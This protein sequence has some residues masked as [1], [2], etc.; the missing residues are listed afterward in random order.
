[1]AIIVMDTD[2]STDLNTVIAGASVGDV[3]EFT[4][5]QEALLDLSGGFVTADGL[6]FRSQ[7]AGVRFPMRVQRPSGSNRF[8]IQGR[9]S[10]KDIEMIIDRVSDTNGQTYMINAGGNNPN[11]FNCLFR[12]DNTANITGIG[13]IEDFSAGSYTKCEFDMRTSG[14]VKGFR[15]A[16]NDSTLNTEARY[17]CCEFYGNGAYATSVGVWDLGTQEEAN[18]FVWQFCKFSLAEVTAG[19]PVVQCPNSSSFQFP[20]I[21]FINNSVDFSGDYFFDMQNILEDLDKSMIMQVYGNIF[22]GDNTNFVFRLGTGDNIDGAALGANSFYNCTAATG[23]TYTPNYSDITALGAP[24]LS[25]DPTNA[26]FL[27]TDP[28]RTEFINADPIVTGLSCGSTVLSA[29]GGSG[30]TDPDKVLSNSVIISGNVDVG[31]VLNTETYGTYVPVATTDVRDGTTFGAASAETG[32]LDLPVV[33]DVKD[34]VQYDNLTKTGTYDPITGQWEA[35]DAADLRDGVSKLQNGVTVNGVLDLPATTDVRSGTQYDNLT[36]TGTAAIPAASDV[37]T[38]TAVDAGTGTLDLPAEADVKIGTQYDGLSKTGTYDGSDR[39]TDPAIANVREGVSYKANSLTNNRTGT[40][41]P[42]AEANIPANTDVREGVTY[43]E[44]NA[45]TGTLNPDA[46]ANIPATGDV[47]SGTTYGEGNLQTG[48]L[49]LPSENDVRDGVTY[50]GLS[51]TGNVELPIES[52]VLVGVGYG[53]NGTEFTGTATGG[54]SGETDPNKVLTTSVIISGNY[55][56]VDSESNVRAGT[57]YGLSQTGTLDVDT[58]A[59][60]PATSDVKAGSPAYGE[61][62]DQ[63]GTLDCDTEANLPAVGEVEAGV[64]YGTSNQFTGTAVLQSP[65]PGPLTIIVYTSD[66]SNISGTTPSPSFSYSF[67]SGTKTA[68]QILSD[69]GAPETLGSGAELEERASDKQFLNIKITR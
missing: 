34:G 56:P 2:V 9:S 35:V 20:S 11:F 6:G 37:R 14:S 17:Y 24:F 46:E 19:A 67:D 43:G 4:G 27:V 22:E 68:D 38:G 51:K 29:G 3:I 13:I 45:Q 48:T 63:N 41:D 50:D 62:L 69:L 33:A 40:L 10:F 18:N 8:Q 23:A 66:G 25:K 12:W 39:W 44:G 42:D 30:E 31:N 26:N 16:S 49:D 52:N 53:S 60:L 7:T 65:Q 28:A 58:E 47:R 21:T 61:N 59:N 55:I 32:T 57:S 36:K 1:M 54:G 15:L 64:N 5:S